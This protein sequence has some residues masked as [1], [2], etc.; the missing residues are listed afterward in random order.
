MVDL[1]QSQYGWTDPVVLS[2]PLHR[3]LQMV[4]VIKQ[5][6]AQEMELQSKLV[7]WQ[8]KNLATY[9]VLTSGIT[10]RGKKKMLTSVHAMHINADDEPVDERSIE[11]VVEQGAL[12]NERKTRPGSFEAFMRMQAEARR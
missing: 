2:L 7:E 6:Q 1:V 3:V 11:E 9:V 10:S 12:P 5:R 8:T 4:E